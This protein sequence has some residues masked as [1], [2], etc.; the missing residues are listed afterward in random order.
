VD[1]VRNALTA[2]AAAVGITWAAAPP[3]RADHEHHHH[4]EPAGSTGAAAPAPTD[5]VD[6]L[7]GVVGARYESRLYDGDYQGASLG[8]SWRRGR[9]GVAAGVAAYRLTRNG[10]VLYGLGDLMFH[11]D[12]ALIERDAAAAG[13]M[14]GVSAPTGDDRKGLGMGHVMIMA[15]GWA[16]WRPAGPLTL[17]ANAGYGR[18]LG[19]AG[20]HAEHGGGSWP[21]VD[22][23]GASELTFGASADVAVADAIAIGAVTAG[24][25]AVPRDDG[26]DRLTAGVHVIVAAGRF[27]TTAAIGAG[28]VGDPYELRGTL[29]TAVRFR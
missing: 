29:S 11:G 3:A 16:T 17:N 22:P 14:L 18:V 15:A 10:Q 23:M 4:H 26:D 21:L 19:S 7:V 5:A 28:L 13:V 9:F 1:R 20:A 27:T 12:V 8:A 2:A 24:A 25:I 6:L